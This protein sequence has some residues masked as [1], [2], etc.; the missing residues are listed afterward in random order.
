MNTT[1]LTKKDFM[2]TT[3]PKW[4]PGCGDFLILNAMQ[5]AFVNS[6]IP[7]ENFVIVGWIGCAGRFPYYMNTYGFHSVHGRAPTIATGVKLNNPE[8]E[9]WVLTWDWDALSIGTNHVFH[10][11]RKNIWVKILLL[12]N[13][14]YALT[15][16][17]LSP[18]SKK[19]KITKTSPS[20]SIKNPVNP[21]K[22]ALN[23]WASFVAR[24][25]DSEMILTQQI[26]E[27]ATSI[28][29]STFVEVLQ[30][31]VTFNPDLSETIRNREE[32]EDYILRI[33]NGK[34][35]IFGKDRNKWIAIEN[36]KPQIVEFEASKIPENVV[37]Y[38]ETNEQLAYIIANLSA[39]EFPIPVWIFKNIPSKSYEQEL[40]ENNNW[41]KK[42]EE[43]LEGSDFWEIK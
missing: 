16:W 30:N 18:T 10:T 22:F 4:C 20:W 21:V 42:I 24:S 26:I 38:N 13:E 8:L 37:I 39:P 23:S 19:W 9:V 1:P 2:S 25:I 27:K 31:C 43:I 11:L 32:K 36:Y 5:N 40:S 34:P 41:N 35:L 33:E 29:S 3:P 28:K 12:N 17:Q 7:R 6:G 15:K 14:I